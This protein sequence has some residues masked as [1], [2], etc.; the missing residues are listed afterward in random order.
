MMRYFSI[1]RVKDLT[2]V[3]RRQARVISVALS[4]L[5]RNQYDSIRKRGVKQLAD[6][7][8]SNRLRTSHVVLQTILRLRQICSQGLDESTDHPNAMQQSAVW[9]RECDYCQTP[10]SRYPDSRACFVGLCGHSYC[11]IC[12]ASL[13]KSSA[14]DSPS[15]QELCPVCGN[16]QLNDND[17]ESLQD[18]GAVSGLSPMNCAQSLQL[19]SKLQTVVSRLIDL[20]GKETGDGLQAEKR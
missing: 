14:E 17:E 13:S 9:R 2:N 15:I 18:L 1:R 3:P 10:F 4:E 7:A 12:Y 19:S 5:E 20:N 11:Q 6:M 8:K 16:S